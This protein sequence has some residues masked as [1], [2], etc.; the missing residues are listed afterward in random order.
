MS[1][2]ISVGDLIKTL[3]RRKR[4]PKALQ[5]LHVKQ[6]FG[7][8]LVK[9][10]GDL[11]KK[12]LDATKASVFKDGALTIIAPPLVCAELTMRSGGLIKA[13]NETLGKRIVR[14]LRFK[15]S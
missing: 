15:N 1:V 4:A 6:A 12:N 10:C 11:S 3:P 14:R 9:V 13:I 2:F 5:A 7:D 8:C